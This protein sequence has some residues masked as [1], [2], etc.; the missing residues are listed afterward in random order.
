MTYQEFVESEQFENYVQDRSAWEEL[1]QELQAQVA[2]TGA[3]ILGVGIVQDGTGK[4]LQDIE[5]IDMGDY[6]DAAVENAR[7]ALEAREETGNPNDCGTRV[8]WERANQLDNGE[9]LSEETISRMAAFERH[10][11]NKEQGEEGRSDC[12][13]L[14]W[15]AWGG[16][17]G[18]E[19]A[20]S[21]L[22]EIEEAREASRDFR[23]LSDAELSQF[24]TWL[25]DVHSDF[26]NGEDTGKVLTQFSQSQAPEAALERVKEAIRSGAVFSHFD[27][28]PSSEL[29]DLRQKMQDMLTD[30]D[31]SLDNMA[32]ELSDTFGV[33]EDKAETWARTETQSVVN[34][35][36]EDALEERQEERDEEFKFK[37]VGSVDS[38]T[39]DS[40]RWLLGGDDLAN[41]I[42][43]TG[44]DGTNPKHGGTP[45][46]M[47]ELKERIEQAADLDP[48]INTRARTFTPHINCRKRYVRV[49]E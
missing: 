13:W 46:T 36:Y 9:D 10:E 32:S 27:E 34:H 49:V 25:D 35:A 38:R 8:G 15:N 5:D 28:L 40:C 6:P 16:D 44:F 48:E 3:N 26:V 1:P 14:M 41:Q 18:I 47:E 22:D 29:M 33:G 37:W 42:S 30:D 17:E 12:G 11:D 2:A 23:H 24:E 7:M 21:K 19:W 45:V 43:G 39:T 4:N 20:Q 31:W